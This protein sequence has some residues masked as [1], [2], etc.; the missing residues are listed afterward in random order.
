MA[1]E[2]PRKRFLRER[3]SVKMLLIILA[4]AIVFFLIVMPFVI[5]QL[6]GTEANQWIN[7]RSEYWGFVFDLFRVVVVVLG[8][9]GAWVLF[10]QKRETESKLDLTCLVTKIS[11]PNGEGN[12]FGL[13]VRLENKGQVPIKYSVPRVRQILFKNE[14]EKPQAADYCKNT[15]R[16]LYDE[17]VSILNVGSTAYEHYTADVKTDDAYAIIFRISVTDGKNTW[18]N[19]ATITNEV[20]SSNHD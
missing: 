1:V 2:I 19:Y 17:T 5:A 12:L 11:K 9:Y 10:F 18:R 14:I 16:V 4:I 20:V 3:I 6:Y 8:A 15:R 13:N 7:E